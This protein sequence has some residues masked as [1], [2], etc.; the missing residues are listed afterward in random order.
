MLCMSKD[1]CIIG[2][3]RIG[4]TNLPEDNKEL[5]ITKLGLDG[6]LK[7]EKRFG[8]IILDNWCSWIQSL[9]DGSYILCGKHR[10]KDTINKSIG[11]LHKLNSNGDSLWY[12]EYAVI[13][14]PEDVNELWQVTP[15]PDKGFA[16]AGTLYP[17]IGSQDKIWVFK[18][19]SLGCLVPNCTGIGITEFNPN[20]GA[21]MLI[22][23]NPF[24][25]AFAI[26]YNIPKESK[27][28][29]FELRDIYGRLVYYTPLSLNVNQLQVV[30]TSLKSGVYFASLVVDDV[31]VCTEKIIKE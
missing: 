4:N 12:R 10:V 19:D 11:W 25:E 1:S 26:N 30:A 17:G 3:Y 22:Y 20:A 13:Q 18:T 14:G 7:W 21:Q 15:T 6:S 9:D 5:Y 24:K 28:G 23:P 27:K 16:A 8:L 2:T 29:V 31:K